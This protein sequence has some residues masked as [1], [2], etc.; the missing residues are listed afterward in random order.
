MIKDVY[1]KK[2]KLIP[3]ERGRLME[4]LRRDDKMFKKFGQVYM[5]LV[6][7]GLVK[8]WHFHEKQDDYFVCLEGRALVALHDMR[9]DSPTYGQSQD[10][11]LA[12]PE[13]EGEHLLIK[14]PKGVAHGFTALDCEQAKIVN[15]PTQKYNYDNPDEIRFPWNDPS[16]NYRWPEEVK[17]GG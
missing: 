4:M 1:I 10:F 15:I 8:A 2:L 14:I 12:A 9:K 11:K 13:L 7:R 5:T 6:K 16:I 3:D 17:D